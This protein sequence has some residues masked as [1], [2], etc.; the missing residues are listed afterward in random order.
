MG[1]R[2]RADAAHTL[3]GSA[4]AVGAWGIADHAEALEHLCAEGS[5]DA[6]RDHLVE[7]ESEID[8][9]GRFVRRHFTAH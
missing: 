4:V 6:F 5:R 3:K 2:D 1:E 8:E 9:V 7:L